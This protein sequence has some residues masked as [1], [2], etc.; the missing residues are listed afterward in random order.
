LQHIVSHYHILRLSQDAF[1][2]RLLE[3]YAERCRNYYVQ[4]KIEL[5][6]RSI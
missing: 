3:P 1:I 2:I 4:T 5:R 6:R